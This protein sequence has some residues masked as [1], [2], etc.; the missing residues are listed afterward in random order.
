[1]VVGQ[2]S[3]AE[4]SG[5]GEEQEKGIAAVVRAMRRMLSMMIADR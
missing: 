3:G 4:G 2:V 1:M 5:R